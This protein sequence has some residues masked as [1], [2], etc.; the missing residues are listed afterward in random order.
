MLMRIVSFILST[1]LTI[2][3]IVVLNKK[4]GAIPPLGKFL[5]PQQGFWQNAEP[6]DYDFS[7]NLYF[8]NLRGK[9]DVYIDDRLVP[10]IFAEIDVRIH[11]GCIGTDSGF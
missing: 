8:D 5:S 4:W 6:T 10:H 3:L 7:E 9:T 11:S 2:I 1:L